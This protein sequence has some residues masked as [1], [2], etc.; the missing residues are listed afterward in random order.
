MVNIVHRKSAPYKPST[1]AK[2]E[3]IVQVL[4]SAI[5][6]ATFSGEDI[7]I[8][9]TRHMLV[10][11]NTINATTGKS[12]LMLLLKRKL[13]TRLDLLKPSVQSHVENKHNFIVE[14]TANRHLQQF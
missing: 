10:Y 1:N 12:P 2:A 13:H 11:R 6:Q 8:A 3:R 4:K 7:D 5:S 9:V 14:R